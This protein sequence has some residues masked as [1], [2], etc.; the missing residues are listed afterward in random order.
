MARKKGYKIKQY[1]N[2]F[3]HRFQSR[4]SPLKIVAVLVS[5]ALLFMLGWALYQ[6]IYDLVT[7]N[8]PRPSDDATP[9]VGEESSQ[10]DDTSQEENPSQEETGTG[11]HSVYVPQSVLTDSA[12]LDA[13][14]QSLENTR[15]T[16]SSLSS[17]QMMERFSIDPS[18]SKWHRCRPRRRMPTR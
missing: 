9:P 4:V 11:I 6:P 14:I 17:G 1:N 3:G 12:Q 16:P 10:G 13:F 18:W 8:T 7:G 5:V 15:S 2:I